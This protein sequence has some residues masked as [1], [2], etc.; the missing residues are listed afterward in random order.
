MAAPPVSANRLYLGNL[1]HDVTKDEILEHFETHGAGTIT[2][3]KIMTGFGFIEYEDPMD[4]RDVVPAFHG[5][6]L[7]GKRLTVQF[8]RGNRPRGEFP[9]SEHRARPSPR[10]TPFRM[11]LSN[12]AEGTSWQDLKDFARGCGKDVVYSEVSRDRDGRGFVEYETSADL[13]AAVE[14]LQGKDF[15]GQSVKCVADEQPDPPPYSGRDRSRSPTRRGYHGYGAPPDGYYDRRG[16]PRGYSPHRD[17]YRRRSPPRRDEYYDS[18]D[19]YRSPP[20]GV[21]GPPPNDGYPPP[22]R[23]YRGDPYGPTPTRRYEE[24]YGNGYDRPPPRRSPPPERYG[25]GYERPRY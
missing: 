13:Q 17:D 5:S 6:D 3:V 19:R 18:R 23:P 10:R 20:R 4:A 8:A 1:P 21:K 2:E 12:L 14:T 7:K 11:Q 22:P 16:P 24:S 25:G 15:K 9:P